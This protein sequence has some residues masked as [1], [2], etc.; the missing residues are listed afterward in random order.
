MNY[1][2]PKLTFHF[3]FLSS[4]LGL[5]TTCPTHLEAALLSEGAVTFFM[6]CTDVLT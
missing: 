3:G 5:Y 1:N 4:A 6:A 2:E